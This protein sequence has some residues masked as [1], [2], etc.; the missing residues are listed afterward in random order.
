M[1]APTAAQER[2]FRAGTPAEQVFRQ[3]A[4]DF[5]PQA[6]KW[7]KDSRV[8]WQGPIEVQL[9]EIDYANKVNWQA[10]KR[11][12]KIAKFA[13]MIKSGDRKP[14]VLSKA[15]G[16]KKYKVVDGHTRALAYEKLG[17]PAR[18]Y[19]CYVPTIT[20]PWDKMHAM[21]RRSNP[22]P[23]TV[24]LAWQAPY[25]AP[26]IWNPGQHLRG[27]HGR[28]A[29]DGGGGKSGGGGAPGDND[30]WAANRETWAQD[31]TQDTNGITPAEQQSLR[32][33]TGVYSGDLNRK[34]RGEP[35]SENPI[36]DEITSDLDRMFA[37]TPGGKGGTFY[38]GVHTFPDVKYGDILTEPGFL[39]TSLS[40]DLAESHGPIMLRIKVPAGISMLDV[41]KI[42]NQQV[43]EAEHLLP[44]GT[45]VKVIANLPANQFGGQEITLEVIPPDVNLARPQQTQKRTRP[46]VAIANAQQLAQISQILLTG[47]LTAAQITAAITA[48]IPGLSAAALAAAV[49][50]VS[51]WPQ[52]PQQGH[53]FGTTE[54][55]KE[56]ELRRAS[57]LMNAYRR[58][59]A[60]QA[61]EARDPDAITEELKDELHYLSQHFQ[62][63]QQR[64]RAGSLVDTAAGTYGPLLG[65]YA[66]PGDHSTPECQE[67][68]GKNFYAAVPPLIGYPG[69][70]H[71]NCKCTPGKPF[72]DGAIMLTAGI[73]WRETSIPEYAL[74]GFQNPAEHPHGYHGHFSETG[75]MMGSETPGQEA[76][77]QAGLKNLMTWAQDKVADAIPGAVS[78]VHF[79]TT[80]RGTEFH[81]I[82]DSNGKYHY[83]GKALNGDIFTT[84]TRK[85]LH[86]AAHTHEVGHNAPKTGKGELKPNLAYLVKAVPPAPVPA[87]GAPTAQV[88]T[89]VHKVGDK[90]IAPNGKQGTVTS[91]KPYQTVPG[92]QVTVKHDDGTTSAG[93][94]LAY[95]N[96]SS[97]TAFPVQQPATTGQ[98][99][100]GDVVSGPGVQ[101]IIDHA[102]A[103]YTPVGAT[104][105]VVSA[106][107]TGPKQYV[108]IKVQFTD[109]HGTSVTQHGSAYA[110]DLSIA[111]ASKTAQPSSYLNESGIPLSVGDHVQVMAGQFIGK[112][113][114]VSDLTTSKF[115]SQAI[116]T[117]MLDGTGS[118]SGKHNF[119]PHSLATISKASGEPPVA[120]QQSTTVPPGM[121]AGAQAKLATA[122]KTAG[123]LGKPIYIRENSAIS[124]AYVITGTVPSHTQEY[125]TVFPSG[126]VMYNEGIKAPA[127]T[128][129]PA[130]AAT[131]N[132]SAALFQYNVGLITQEEFKAET[133][134]TLPN[135]GSKELT[136][137]FAQAI[138]KSDGVSMV[139]VHDATEGVWVPF[140]YGKV[141]NAYAE[142]PFVLI[143]K[144]GTIV[145][146]GT[147]G[148]GLGTVKPGGSGLTGK[149]GTDPM[150]SS[151]QMKWMKY[152]SLHEI[153][154]PED[155]YAQ[156]NYSH[157]WIIKSEH[158][159]NKGKSVG[160]LTQSKKDG[161]FS[162]HSYE[163][164]AADSYNQPTEHH[165]MNR[166]FEFKKPAAWQKAHGNLSTDDVMKPSSLAGSK[167]ADSGLKLH[168]FSP[169]DHVIITDTGSN[170]VVTSVG[171]A[172]VNVT[173][174]SGSSISGGYLPGSLKHVFG[175]GGQVSPSPAPAAV[176]DVQAPADLKTL[177]ASPMWKSLVSTIASVGF[178]GTKDT[179]FVHM[180][181]GT[182]TQTM[183]NPKFTPG[184]PFKG[185]ENIW[186]S[187]AQSSVWHWKPGDAAT[188]AQSELTAQL[189]EANQPHVAAA[190]FKKQQAKILAD[191]ELAGAVSK[192]PAQV[193]TDYTDIKSHY[194]THGAPV[195]TGPEITSIHNYQGS[196]YSA[197]NAALRKLHQAGGDP[198]K[199]DSSTRTHIKRIDAAMKKW[200]V[201]HDITVSRKIGN[202]SWLPAESIVGEKI[203]EHGYSSTSF[204]QDV[205]SGNVKMWIHVPKGMNAIMMNG[206]KGSVHSSEKEL[207]LPR[208][209][210]FVVI[211]DKMINGSRVLIMEAL[212]PN[213]D[214][215]IELARMM[216]WDPVRLLRYVWDAKTLRLEHATP[217]ELEYV[218]ARMH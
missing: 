22:S 81:K 12:K 211:E 195:L 139:V 111:T 93:S 35:V 30:S 110:H 137:S 192:I 45:K 63:S 198:S 14:I 20:G 122:K 194:A 25:N 150:K 19:V 186:V 182:W 84:A 31:A 21:Q 136:V 184:S 109:F 173:V 5:P 208:G 152:Y 170:G 8:K 38:R 162:L 3:E 107:G 126:A 164:P 70:V 142:M 116:V 9:S 189:V 148:T 57:F 177:T 188:S 78:G 159:V 202:A 83:L 125:W 54:A 113:G 105:E 158:S 134:L 190:E 206:I 61:A 117:V 193:A 128:P 40:R 175:K 97:G 52:P 6:V 62:A 77:E 99:K 180:P 64:E 1:P 106:S 197:I 120:S 172:F 135:E 95:K 165:A 68:D 204:S 34:L 151:L 60:A 58:L 39:S 75:D 123:Q 86:A 24:N 72:A 94:E 44:R 146:D 29:P 46:P 132:K 80:P 147:G 11:T 26:D 200:T 73:P 171:A 10:Y 79:L 115:T 216:K 96:A 127:P 55:V 140:P 15:P 160:R 37:K 166:L 103:S 51:R 85:Q 163:N 47:G 88:T 124:G 183:E 16:Q 100:K 218:A 28:F 129:P 138:A 215:I 36:H 48:V 114:T 207:L 56:N 199:I 149:D 43:G 156:K 74:A 67:A 59:R 98:F 27:Y 118:A 153:S 112:T 144:A 168:D 130:P 104:G 76:W 196:G 178:A 32:R 17:H 66:A 203:T 133:G 41:N 145:S 49:A 185:K 141:T 161:T 23:K 143:N 179:W 155:N 205:W 212:G 157:T 89:G 71:A 18:A 176:P 91:V 121:P 42:L 102:P 209:T 210:R 217:E 154:V 101:N 65:W 2:K 7:I 119:Y 174:N 187:T 90:V 181:D 131:Q 167:S 214:E 82:K 69:F 33:Y 108:S 53:G 92:N 87:P 169:G 213:V 4:E 13:Q 201:P 50:L 191:Q